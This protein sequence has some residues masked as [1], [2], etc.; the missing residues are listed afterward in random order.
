MVR[1]AWNTKGDIQDLEFETQ[2]QRMGWLMFVIMSV[3]KL[4]VAPHS[5]ETQSLFLQKWFQ[6]ISAR[7][8]IRI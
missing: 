7:H 1:V 5:R 2:I 4:L 3:P 6:I 8:E